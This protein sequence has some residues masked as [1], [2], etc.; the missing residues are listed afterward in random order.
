MSPSPTHQQIVHQIRT[1]PHLTQLVHRCLHN[2]FQCIHAKL[3]H[4]TPADYE[5]FVSIIVQAKRAFMWT[6]DGAQAFQHL[7]LSIKRFVYIFYISQIFFNAD[8]L[9]FLDRRLAR[10]NFGKSLK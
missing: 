5:D 10:K 7:M 4:V 9:L 8:C 6:P 1:T 3:Y 2:Y